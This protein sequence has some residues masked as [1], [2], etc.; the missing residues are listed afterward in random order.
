[1]KLHP[2]YVVNE[3][4]ERTAV[5]LPMGDDRAVIET[6]EDQLDAAYLDGAVAGETEF[7]PYAQARNPCHRAGPGARGVL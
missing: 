5:I 6:L 7:V 3:R 4:G 1:M 2:L